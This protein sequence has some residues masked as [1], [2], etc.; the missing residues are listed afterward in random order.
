MADPGR[1]PDPAGEDPGRATAGACVA[2]EAAREV[3]DA[4]A[5]GRAGVPRPV[6][7]PRNARAVRGLVA[8]R[9]PVTDGE[10]A[11]ALRA[12]AAGR[13]RAAARA[14]LD[15]AADPNG[16][17]DPESPRIPDDRRIEALLRPMTRDMAEPN[18]YLRT[19]IL[20]AS[21]V[22]LRLMLFEGAVKFLS[23]GIE[24]L[25]RQDF[26]A[27]YE[28]VSK[29]QNIVLELLNALDREKAP[30]LC[31][32][33]SGLYTFM[34]LELVEGHTTRDEPRLREVLRLLEFERETWVM[35]MN[36]LA[37]GEDGAGSTPG[38][39]L[40]A[41]TNGQGGPGTTNGGSPTAPGS[42]PAPAETN[43]AGSISLR[44]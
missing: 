32:K 35:L 26:E 11:V 6:A 12:V 10:A 38:D 29:T 22:E 30:D 40:A 25:G 28:G 18:P 33:L 20:T 8:G 39:A 3:G 16:P 27:M 7:S 13:A 24:A 17:G 37:A 14:A 4:G 43:T 1:E 44:G 15:R 9:L 34:Y 19:K 5:A 42:R 2:S 41:A 21:P 31:D 36:Q 23:Q